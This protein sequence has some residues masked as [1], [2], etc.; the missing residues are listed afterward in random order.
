MPK[1]RPG[2]TRLCI[3]VQPICHSRPKLL[4]HITGDRSGPGLRYP[5][6][7]KID[8]VEGH[9]LIPPKRMRVNSKCIFIVSLCHFSLRMQ[10]YFC[11]VTSKPGHS[12]RIFYSPA[13]FH[14][15]GIAFLLNALIGNLPDQRY[16]IDRRG[17]QP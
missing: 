3:L 5:V 12:G 15:K 4:V 2:A 11:G 10:L 16:G 1:A 17:I 8:R 7:F 13:L 14:F 9:S 6:Y